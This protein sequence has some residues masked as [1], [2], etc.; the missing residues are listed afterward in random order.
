MNASHPCPLRARTLPPQP[1]SW[2]PPTQHDS[3]CILKTSSR[4]QDLSLVDISG[5]TKKKKRCLRFDTVV[6]LFISFCSLLDSVSVFS[7]CYHYHTRMLK[8]KC[9]WSCTWAKWNFCPFLMST[10][11]FT[12]VLQLQTVVEEQLSPGFGIRTS[13]AVACPI[14]T[15]CKALWAFYDL[16]SGKFD[17]LFN[18]WKHL[19]CSQTV[20]STPHSK[21]WLTWLKSYNARGINI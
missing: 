17:Y 2:S 20:V 8:I 1:N 15:L 3:F 10:F 12:C 4:N 16:S 13:R 14:Q 19:L 6:L 5:H 7:Y 11:C 21:T 18:Y 9:I